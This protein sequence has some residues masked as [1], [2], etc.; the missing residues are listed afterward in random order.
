[1]RRRLGWLFWI[2]AVLLS[3]KQLLTER[4][5]ATPEEPEVAV[6]PVP[7]GWSV[8]QAWEAISR[9]DVL[10][11][12]EPNWATVLVYQGRLK[13]VYGDGRH[14]EEHGPVVGDEQ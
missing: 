2:P 5:W 14:Q 1:M 10:A 11:D 8:E 6:I 7:R 9:G 3:V 4:E 13:K 12:P